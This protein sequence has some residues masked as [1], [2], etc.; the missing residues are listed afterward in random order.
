MMGGEIGVK[1]VEG[2]GSTFW[3][4]LDLTNAANQAPLKTTAHLQNQK[5]LV[6]DDNLTNRS[7]LDQLLTN[8]QVEHALAES[9]EVALKF[10]KAASDDGHP[11]DIAI[12]D[13]QMPE[14]DGAQLGAAIKKDSSL[15]STHLVALISQG[16]RG[17]KEKSKSAGF[18][19]YLNKPIDQFALYNAL[20][21]VADLTSDVQALVTAHSAR[22]FPQFS[23]RV[24]VVED[25]IT[26]QMVA[27]GMLKKF[28][29]L[30]DL[31]ANGEEAVHALET[32]P[33]DLV[34]MD[35]QMPL[36]DGYEAT[37]R[38][39][40]SQSKVLDRAVPVVAMTANT[41]Q[42]DR[43]KCLAVGM[44]DFISKPVSPTKLLQALQN[45][46]PVMTLDRHSLK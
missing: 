32:L 37:R 36:L 45:W 39:R 27:K 18:D 2:K 26:N 42:G 9:G 14:M 44:D 23:A 43:E 1:S 40:D 10:L 22:D 34:F 24:L 25:N 30:A 21:Q 28:G 4:T 31:A 33:Y 11:Y 7:L 8:W 46:L 20:L 29:I 13:M 19:G 6:V 15:S 3:F 16:R 41:M 5:I 12:L 17:N 35:C 38:I